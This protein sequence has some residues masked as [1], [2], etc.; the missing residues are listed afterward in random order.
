MILVAVAGIVFALNEFRKPDYGQHLKKARSLVGEPE[1]TATSCECNKKLTCEDGSEF[2][3]YFYSTNDGRSRFS[4]MMTVITIP[5]AEQYHLIE[6][7]SYNRSRAISD[8][9]DA[10]D[11]TVLS[12]WVAMKPGVEPDLALLAKPKDLKDLRSGL[13]KYGYKKVE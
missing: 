12:A 1:Y 7:F 3:L 11:D 2:Y 6:P 4:Y 5:N 13:D 9:R 10:S 8:E